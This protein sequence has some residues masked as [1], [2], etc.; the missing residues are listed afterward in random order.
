MSGQDEKNYNLITDHL[1][2]KFTKLFEWREY[3]N[4]RNSLF[5]KRDSFYVYDY[6]GW[7][8]KR[9]EMDVIYG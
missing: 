2:D 3:T 9:N 7:K 1:N 8:F 4:G 6:N 5:L